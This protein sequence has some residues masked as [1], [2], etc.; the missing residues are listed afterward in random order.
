MVRLKGGGCA[1]DPLKYAT[2]ITRFIVCIS[3]I[4]REEPRIQDRCPSA[5]IPEKNASKVR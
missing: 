1:T 5:K 3:Q 4:V 2:G